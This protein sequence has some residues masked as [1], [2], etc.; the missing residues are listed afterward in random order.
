MSADRTI[1]DMNAPVTS[2]DE[3][4]A[5]LEAGAKPAEDWRIGTEH[6]KFGFDLDDLAP[7]P[8]DGPRGIEQ[9]LEGLT[10]FGWTRQEEAGRLVALK[11]NKGSVT[12]EPGGQVELSGEPLASILH[13]TADYLDDHAAGGLILMDSLTDLLAARG[14]HHSISELVLTLKGLRRIARKWGSLILLLLNKDAV[15]DQELGN[16]M[17]AVDGTLQFEWETGGNERVRTMYVP[18][19]R[20]V[21]SQLENED[22]IRFETEIH[23][24]GFD[25]S[26]VRKIR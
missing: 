22:I 11:M 25:V 7:L 18:E 16:L 8:F 14:R 26:N 1:P 9:V 2:R 20:G 5:Y 4:V 6:E 13:N 10:R 21:L 15:T 3:L 19:F 24:A 12:L 17:T 23:D